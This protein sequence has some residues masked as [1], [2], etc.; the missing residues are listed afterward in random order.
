MDHMG[1]HKLPVGF[2]EAF[3]LY[4]P[5]GCTELIGRSDYE[6]LLA[7]YELDREKKQY[8][9][10]ALLA[11]ENDE[12]VL[13]FSRFFVWDMCSE[14]NKYD[15]DN[16][17]ELMPSCLGKYNEAYAFLVLLSCVPVAEK[18]M[19]RRQIPKEYYQDIPHRM[20]RDQMKRYKETGR[21]DVEDMPWKM[22]FYTLTIF[23]LDR[24]LFIPYENGEGFRLY[25]SN[26][27]GKVI[28]IPESGCIYDHEGQL[29]S[30]PPEDE[31]TAQS[32]GAE[33][34]T[35]EDEMQTNETADEQSACGRE[36]D[37]KET[38]CGDGSRQG[39]GYEYATRPAKRPET[40]TTTRTETEREITGYYMNPVGYTENRQITIDKDEY[41][42]VLKPG[43]YLIALHIPGGEGY[44]PERMHHSMALALDFFA[45]YYPELTMKGFWSSSWLYDKRLEMIIGKGRNI[46][47]VQNLMFRYSDGENG[48]M[49]YIHLYKN[50][51]SRL[52]DYPCT[53]S[54]QKGAREFLLNGNRFCTTGMMILKEEALNGAAYYTEEDERHFYELMKAEGIQ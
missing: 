39:T 46:T 51:E 19:I 10:E 53:T 16:Y 38:A 29:L 20:L 17:T 44:T 49:L 25:R 43:D 54:L 34:E 52:R 22:N 13:L 24:F 47:N 32:E 23:L 42:E 21:I 41:V 33:T 18:E 14:R 31:A 3:S 45:K 36:E 35:P 50:M 9:D 6:A 37:D 26:K 28:G 1:M 48:H 2:E 40:F 4:K 5:D 7:P 15:I 12:K 27:T 11:I 30:W 8:L